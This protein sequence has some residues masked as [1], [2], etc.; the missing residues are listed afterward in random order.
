M[1]QATTWGRS[2][3]N[4]TAV[5][6]AFSPQELLQTRYDHPAQWNPAV[7]HPDDAMTRCK[8]VLLSVAHAA[9]LYSPPDLIRDM[10]DTTIY[11]LLPSTRYSA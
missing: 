9:D 7:Q 6:A 4:K 5:T 11:T 10:A 8:P 3:A 2:C 1:Q